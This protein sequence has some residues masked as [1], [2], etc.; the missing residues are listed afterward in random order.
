MAERVR[1]KD[2]RPR[3]FHVRA[4]W[5]LRGKTGVIERRLGAFKNPEDLAYHRPAEK[6]ELLRVRFTMRDLWGETA[7]NP[8]D[9]L[10]AEIFAHWLEP[11][12]EGAD[13][14]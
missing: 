3:G 9:T 7:E 6:I 5:Y 8:D 4:P 14:A 1:V 13:A 11:A 2:W 12:E 10:D